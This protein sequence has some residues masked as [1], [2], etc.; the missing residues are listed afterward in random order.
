[1]KINVPLGRLREGLSK[2]V[3]R[4]LEV[5]PKET[6]VVDRPS[7][8]KKSSNEAGQSAETKK[9]GSRSQTKSKSHQSRE[10]SEKK[11]ESD[12]KS[13]KESQPIKQKTKHPK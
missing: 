10:K 9:Q 6:T 11:S 12:S 5:R 7:I 13:A 2:H 4:G 3:N 1:M 8:L